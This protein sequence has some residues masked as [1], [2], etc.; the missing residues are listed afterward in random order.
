MSKPFNFID[1]LLE[2]T[3]IVESPTS[4]LEWCAYTTIASVMR[5]NIYFAVPSRRTRITPNLYV[6]LVGDSGSTRKS[7]PLKI[8]NFLLRNV[9]NTKLIEGRVSIQGVLKELA[10]V[11]TATIEHYKTKTTFRVT[12]KFAAGLLYSE[13]LAAFIV[14]DP[15]V[16]SILTDIYD[17][18]EHHDIILKTQETLH[19][20]KV[21]VTL[22][23]ATNAAFMQDMFTKEDIY[24]GLVGRTFF[25]IE[26]K[27]RHKDLGL[28]DETVEEDW[29][30]LIEHLFKLSKL[31]GVAKLTDEALTWMEKWY[32]ETNF[33]LYESKTGYEHRAHTH[34]L[35]LALV[36]AAAEEGFDLTV[37][38]DHCQR[39]VDIVTNMRKNYHKI[40]ATAGY[41]NNQTLQAIKD[42]TVIMF[43][44]DGAAM[45][46]D[47]VFRRLFGRVDTESFDKAI[48]TLQQT[49]FLEVTGTS[50]PF[51]SLSKK[52]REA[53][54]GEVK[55]TA[56]G[57]V[58]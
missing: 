6:V 21:C 7:T 2:V 5:H 29:D 56:E 15:S 51:Y 1:K 30:P 26:E 42:I 38:L 53:I 4:Y 23:S 37:R 46:R 11:K 13:E 45:E 20:N 31:E 55:F 40:V 43:Q 52:G 44:N 36:L 58:N 14:K 3:K 49:G 16:T 9:G 32:N 8:C 57:K 39:A 48:M 22:F 35:K 41:S 28:R 54:L 10:E 17:Y 33:T 34:A 19:L 47:E 18:K 50:R 12:Q 24:G 25:I 27:A